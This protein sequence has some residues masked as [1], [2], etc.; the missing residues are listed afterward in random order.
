MKRNFVLMTSVALIVLMTMS[1][2]AF[3]WPWQATG[4]VTFVGPY[5]INEGKTRTVNIGGESYKIEVISVSSNSATFSIDNEKKEITEGTIG[6]IG[7][8]QIE[9][10]DLSTTSGIF[11]RPFVKFRV[12]EVG[13]IESGICTDSDGYLSLEDSYYVKGKT[14][15]CNGNGEDACDLGVIV[16][17]DSCVKNTDFASSGPE[18]LEHICTPLKQDERDYTP[19]NEGPGAISVL[20]FCPNGCYDGACIEDEKTPLT[21]NY[22][23]PT[24][25]EYI[26][27]TE[28]GLNG[29]EIDA[30]CSD[31]YSQIIGMSDVHCPL[32]SSPWLSGYSYVYTSL[33]S[34]INNKGYLPSSVTYSCFNNDQ[35]FEKPWSVT[36]VCCDIQKDSTSVNKPVSTN[37]YQ[38][39]I[40]SNGKATT[41]KA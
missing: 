40:D 18:L 17:E 34:L 21:G 27:V 5:K 35:K 19:G 2:M 33:T 10:T 30:S 28:E 31:R 38:V 15:G 4:K 26:Y 20:Y 25:C 39:T 22:M 32:G 13:E 1:V 36:I 9:V 16:S 37:V 3:S 41:T 24:S 8:L 14:T 6:T 29:N 12:A 11:S 7:I 23:D